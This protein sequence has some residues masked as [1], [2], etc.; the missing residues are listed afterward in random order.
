MNDETEALM[1]T[2]DA[3]AVISQQCM[4]GKDI[5]CEKALAMFCRIYGAEAGNL[6]LKC[7]PYGGV[8][9]AGGIAAK[10]L[11]IMQQGMFMDGFLAKGRY[12]NALA[13]LSVKVCTNPEAGL[14]GAACH[15]Q[16][17]IEG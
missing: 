4:Q 2:Q 3:A 5:L 16:K 12:K 1:Q 17:L 7:L 9:L 13:Q 11:T 10:I 6:A 14:F 15:A 8:I